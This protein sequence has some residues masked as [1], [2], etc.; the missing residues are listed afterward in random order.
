MINFQKIRNLPSHLIEL[1]KNYNL[2]QSNPPSTDEH[3]LRN[4]R[5]ST[6]LFL[7]LLTFSLI[8][9]LI[10]NALITI[11]K[12]DIK[13]NPTYTE[14]R[15]LHS[16]YSNT[17]TCP[18][19]HISIDY[20][21]I[22]QVNYTLHEICSSDF[23]TQKWFQ[24]LIESY[25]KNNIHLYDFRWTGSFTFQA[26]NAL[27]ELINE[28]IM[29]SFLQL[30]S[31]RYI[32]TAIISLDTF[33]KELQ[34]FTNLFRSTI[35]TNFLDLFKM[36]RSIISIN[37]FYSERDTNYQIEIDF[38]ALTVTLSETVYG[39][40]NCKLSSKCL[41]PTSFYKYPATRPLFTIKG[42][43][44]GCYIVEALMESTLEC[45]YNQT[46]LSKSQSID[47]NITRTSTLKK[48]VVNHTLPT[49]METSEKSTAKIHTTEA[50]LTELTTQENQIITTEDCSSLFL[51][52]D[53]YETSEI[54]AIAIKD[55]NDDDRPDIVVVV[56][57]E[58]QMKLLLNNGDGVI[59]AVIVAKQNSVILTTMIAT[60][61]TTLTPLS[62]NTT[63]YTEVLI[64]DVKEHSADIRCLLYDSLTDQWTRTGRLT[65]LGL[66]HTASLLNNGLVLITG[67]VSSG[68]HYS[69]VELYNAST[70]KWTG[71]RNMV[72]TRSKHIA[73]VL[74]DG[75]VLV[76]GGIDFFLTSTRTAELYDPL[77]DIWK[78]TQ[79]MTY[80]RY[81]H[82]ASLLQ[83]GKILLTGG[84]DL[85]TAN[86][87]YD[88]TQ[89][90]WIKAGE[91][92]VPRRYHTATVLTNG[93]VLVIGG[94]DEANYVWNDGELLDQVRSTSDKDAA[95]R[96]LSNDQAKKL[97][98]EIGLVELYRLNTL[99]AIFERT[100][101][102]KI[103][104]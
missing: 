21:E 2:F 72:S 14:Y 76:T 99:D 23:V 31:K 86:E 19:K 15:R 29:D 54:M 8:I 84:N 24:Y 46:C 3:D 26:L 75:K 43:Y 16:L 85:K 62:I 58:Y 82:R 7:I 98:G 39:K 80:P 28:I 63:T 81:S 25:D 32:S 18:C 47:T 103:T 78:S 37:A 6:R 36:I 12:T 94:R 61:K 49:A 74:K 42:L 10:Y 64:T 41:Y 92:K 52:S 104:E 90:K 87:L 9:L 88:P 1:I 22:L 30:Q 48:T 60:T 95:R 38:F 11:T 65:F 69:Y 77:T 40:C 50:M 83:N 4:Q 68:R 67:G 33:E 102:A 45:F 73:T 5:I 56:P 55:I 20:K 17:L 79:D 91:M 44:Q 100:V 51:N 34:L 53:A 59:S 101:V 93:K 96:A 70:N 66:H 35:T 89:D 27:C 13:R 97:S 71:V 57:I